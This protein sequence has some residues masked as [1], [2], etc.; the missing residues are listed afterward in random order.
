MTAWR[1]ENSRPL[2]RRTS[3]SC[4]KPTSRRC[5]ST[6]LPGRFARDGWDIVPI[7][8]AYRDPIAAVEPDTWFLGEGRVAALA[9]IAGADPRDLVHERTDEAALATL[10]NERVLS[11][12]APPCVARA[13]P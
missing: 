9:Q 3:F 10:F 7:D 6:T 4:T 13:A 11:D 5:S 1:V 2:T 12:R 8:E